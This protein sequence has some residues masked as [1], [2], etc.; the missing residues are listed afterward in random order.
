MRR[1]SLKRRIVEDD[2]ENDLERLFPSA[3]EGVDE[4]F[5]QQAKRNISNQAKIA[6]ILKKIG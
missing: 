3:N 4:V 6:C 5:N 1:F 2:L